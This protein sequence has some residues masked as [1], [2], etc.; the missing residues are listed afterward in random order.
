MNSSDISQGDGYT[1]ST[2]S[3]AGDVFRGFLEG[4]K[5]TFESVGTMMLSCRSACE[6]D[7]VGTD[8]RTDVTMEEP[9]TEVSKVKELCPATVQCY[10]P[11]S[12]PSY[13]SSGFPMSKGDTITNINVGGTQ[14]NQSVTNCNY[15]TPSSILPCRFA[16][17]TSCPSAWFAASAA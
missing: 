2:R 7:C 5:K 12:V 16:D 8:I 6:T 1:R 9:L 15:F 4:F 13:V 3:T 17:V 14:T 10:H 11:V